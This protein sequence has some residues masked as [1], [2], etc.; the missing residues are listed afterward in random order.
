M[1]TTTKATTA[2]ATGA[3]TKKAAATAATNKESSN[4][5]SSSSSS[6]STSP[7]SPPPRALSPLLDGGE[8]GAE[9]GEDGGLEDADDEVQGHVD[10]RVG[11]ALQA[12]RAPGEQAAAR[13]QVHGGG[14]GGR[15]VLTLILPLL[16]LPLLLLK[17]C[18]P[19][20]QE[21]HVHT[22]PTFPPPSPPH[23]VVEES[24]MMCLFSRVS[25][26]KKNLFG[27]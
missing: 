21:H 17:Y 26:K 24:L 12:A 5:S 8:D 4:S 27:L 1:R 16:P 22:E 11:Q 7:P 2:A 13:L 15:H 9:V 19:S 14:G 25:A 3:T 18:P 6:N 10:A 23:S 20:L